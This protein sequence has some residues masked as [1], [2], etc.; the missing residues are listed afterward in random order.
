MVSFG[1][2]TNIIYIVK[3]NKHTSNFIFNVELKSLKTNIFILFLI[4]RTYKCQLGIYYIF[5]PF[6]HTFYK[7]Y[8]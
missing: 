6:H 3:T 7:R 4:L 8:L 1:L 2:Q 5:I